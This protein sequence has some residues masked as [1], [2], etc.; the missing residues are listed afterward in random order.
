MLG[1][2]LSLF[3]VPSTAHADMSI[4]TC[5]FKGS[6]PPRILSGGGIG[7]VYHQGDFKLTGSRGNVSIYKGTGPIWVIWEKFSAT[8]YGKVDFQINGNVQQCTD[9]LR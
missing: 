5:R 6:Q 8:K 2:F 9:Y 1:F 7:K 4:G 3:L